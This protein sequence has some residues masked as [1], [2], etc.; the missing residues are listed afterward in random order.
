[1]NPFTQP[2]RVRRLWPLLILALLTLIGGCALHRPSP[3]VPGLVLERDLLSSTFEFPHRVSSWYDLTPAN[4]RRLSSGRVVDPSAQLAAHR[5]LPFGSWLLIRNPE[6]GHTV[7][8]EVL[9]RGPYRVG[10]DLDLSKE[11]FRALAPLERGI[12]K[13]EVLEVWIPSTLKTP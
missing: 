11:A 4:V 2:A 3:S 13:Y 12:I 7:R 1:M 8:V 6:N 5:S 9:D 10:R